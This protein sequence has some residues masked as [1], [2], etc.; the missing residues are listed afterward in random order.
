MKNYVVTYIWPKT[1]ISSGPIREWKGMRAI[2]KKKGEILEN[3]GKSA[4]HLKIFWKRA[5]TI[6]LF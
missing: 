3:L 2:F 6:T 5:A 4:Q 1:L